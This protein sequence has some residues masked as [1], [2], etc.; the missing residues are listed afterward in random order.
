[1]THGGR[2][3]DKISEWLSCYTT[4]RHGVYL[5]FTLSEHPKESINWRRYRTGCPH[6]RVRWFIDADTE[7]GEPLYQVY[8][9]QN[10]PA[11]TWEE[12]EKCLVSRTE[13]WRHVE[14]RGGTVKIPITMDSIRENTKASARRRQPTA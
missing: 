1:M 12:Q 7:A 3:G 9:L 2:V 5:E 6:Y 14:A 8:C 11:E 4:E 13:C 10:T